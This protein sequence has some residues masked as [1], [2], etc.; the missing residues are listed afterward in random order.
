M[1]RITRILDA[2]IRAL[3]SWLGKEPRVRPDDT[4]P[5]GWWGDLDTWATDDL[6]GSMI[7]LS[8][9]P[10]A[11][12]KRIMDTIG[13]PKGKLQENA[14]L[15]LDQNEFYPEIMWQKRGSPY[16]TLYS[17]LN[18]FTHFTGTVLP[19][20]DRKEI[21]LHLLDAEVIKDT[22]KKSGAHNLM[23]SAHASDYMSKKIKGYRAIS[24]R[25][26]PGTWAWDYIH[27]LW[28]AISTSFKVS[29]GFIYDR[30]DNNLLDSAVHWGKV[31][32]GH[33]QC[34]IGDK[35]KKDGRSNAAVIG[36]NNYGVGTQNFII[37]GADNIEKR[38]DP[39]F[40]RWYGTFI[41]FIKE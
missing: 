30:L 19:E 10:N 39:E 22:E 26:T 33:A 28:H 15:I 18:C 8:E 34:F 35:L 41:C 7:N 38:Y 24:Y 25:V 4:T 6:V 16:C 11:T 32:N 1:M 31:Y 14:D 27:S 23:T 17:R 5:K 29:E 40:H 21:L 2:I 3:E 9:L 37:Y 36:I 20:E 13:L 12:V